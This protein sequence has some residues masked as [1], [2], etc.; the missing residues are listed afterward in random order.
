MPNRHSVYCIT[1]PYMLQ[2]I[3]FN[4]TPEQRELALRSITISEQFRGQ[5]GAM[6]KEILAFMKPVSAELK[7][8]IVFDAKNGTQL[9]GTVVRQEGD[10]PVTDVAVN[11]AYDGLGGTYDMYYEAYGRNSIDGKGLRLDSTVHYSRGYDNSFGCDRPRTDAWRYP[12]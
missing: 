8:R 5:R 11:E 7:Q 12:V 10:S 9:P 3:V 1:P 6:T 4:G 2:Q